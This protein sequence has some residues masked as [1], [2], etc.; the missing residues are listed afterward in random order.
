VIEAITNC[1]VFPSKVQA[2]QLKVL[3]GNHELT[4][5]KVYA[6]LVKKES[7]TGG[8]TIS[9]KK[10]RNYFP[11]SYTKEQIEGVIYALLEQWKENEI[12]EGK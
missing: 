4:E 6:T 7:G 12:Q 9:A 11:E 5:S 10:I 8:V 3:S 2:E 1:N